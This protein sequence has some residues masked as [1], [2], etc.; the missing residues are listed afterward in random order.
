MRAGR[1]R[2]GCSALPVSSAPGAA[3]GGGGEARGHLG[4]WCRVGMC[5]PAG[6]SPRSRCEAATGRVRESRASEGP[7]SCPSHRASRQAAGSGLRGLVWSSQRVRSVTALSSLGTCSVGDMDQRLGESWDADSVLLWCPVQLW[8]F[9]CGGRSS[10]LVTTRKSLG[11]FC[12]ACC[13]A[14]LWAKFCLILFSGQV[15]LF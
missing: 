7:S 1:E 5:S 2:W 12:F 8:R 14:S 9:G 3:A 15:L 11:R 10:P 13:Q 4:G 6:T